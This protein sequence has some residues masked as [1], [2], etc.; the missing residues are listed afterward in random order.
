MTTEMMMFLIVAGIAVIIAFGIANRIKEGRMQDELRQRGVTAVAR[1][2]G[3]VSGTH[4]STDSDNNTTYTDYYYVDYQYTVNGKNYVRRDSITSDVFNSL[5]EGQPIEV[6]YL[7]EKP[8]EARRA[9]I[10]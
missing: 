3:L 5:Q 1:I 6:V 4:T 8:G 10:L 7:P 2:T 9:S